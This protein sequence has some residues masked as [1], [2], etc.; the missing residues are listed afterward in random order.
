MPVDSGFFGKGVVN[1]DAQ[2]LA[3]AEADRADRCGRLFLLPVKLQHRP[4]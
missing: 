2:A 4:P 1:R 3:L